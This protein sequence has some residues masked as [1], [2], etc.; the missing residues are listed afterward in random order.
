MLIDRFNR[1]S[2]DQ[3]IT[4]SGATPCETPVDLNSA[5]DAIGV[6]RYL[7][8]LCK[9]AVAGTGTTVQFIFETDSD[10]AFGSATA[11]WTSPAIAKATLVAGYYVAKFR[12]PVGMER[13]SR[14]RY[15]TDNTYTAGKFDSWLGD[16]GDNNDFTA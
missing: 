10:S 11:L 12:V 15:V 5:G 16:A 9:E 6:E 4:A 7:H 8:I 14:V 2:K 1:Y 13:Y 3:A